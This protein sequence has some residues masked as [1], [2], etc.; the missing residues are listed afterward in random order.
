MDKWKHLLDIWAAPDLNGGTSETETYGGTLPMDHIAIHLVEALA[1][2]INNP[3]T[4]VTRDPF[5]DHIPVGW[6]RTEHSIAVT[7]DDKETSERVRE[8]VM[9]F[10]RAKERYARFVDTV[11]QNLPPDWGK[12]SVAPEWSEPQVQQWMANFFGDEA[13]NLGQA[14][15]RNLNSIARHMG[16][17]GSPPQFVPFAERDQ[18]DL[19]RLARRL[20]HQPSP[21]QLEALR[22]EFD[23]DGNLWRVFY[24]SSFDWFK[25]DFDAAIYRL[26]QRQSQG[27]AYVASPSPPTSGRAGARPANPEELARLREQVLT[28]DGGCCQ[29]C[30]ASGK[31][32]KLELD[33]IVSRDHGGPD[34]IGNL[35]TLCSVCNG[36]RY[37]G[38]NDI[39]FRSHT[40][41][42]SSPKPAQFLGANAGEDVERSLRRLVNF[43]Y[44]CGAVCAIR[45]SQRRNGKHY[46]TWEIELYAPND[47]SW[48]GQHEVALIQHIATQF[49][50]EHVTAVV[51]R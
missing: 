45:T 25:M 3:D 20:Y 4:P 32:V 43:F 28:R 6:Y 38:V 11:F 18:F 12:E 27:V 39:N 46:S 33:H 9:V 30:G 2:R 41:P 34:T 29:A 8:F 7:E 5:L 13:D 48:L 35:Q 15:A 1:R 49:G 37:K 36:T 40:S 24:K 31:G 51:V 42:L 19:D 23:V 50:C 44:H 21:S 16:A 10:D 17:N 14:L 22:A 47:P 26:W